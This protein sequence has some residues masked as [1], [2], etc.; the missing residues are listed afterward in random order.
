[1]NVT[2][3]VLVGSYLIG[4]VNFAILV[5]RI[6]GAVDP[7]TVHS[8]NPGVANVARSSGRTVAGVVLALDLARAALVEIVAAKLCAPEAIAWAGLALVVGNRYPL[9]HGL[10]GGKGVAAYLGFVAAL[11]PLGAAAA[12]AVWLLAY[13]A[14]RVVAIASTAMAV[15]LAVV[16]CATL[17][18]SALPLSATALSLLLIVHGHRRNWR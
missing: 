17:P 5:T 1:M 11:H 16:A 14:A 7:R 6:S 12:C 15:A 18:L 9:W 4:S 3:A 10:R 8:R 13:A 2:G